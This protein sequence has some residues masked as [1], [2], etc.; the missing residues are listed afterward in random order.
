MNLSNNIS[1]LY[2]FHFRTHD[3]FFAIRDGR[4][5]SAQYSALFFHIP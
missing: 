2:V 5:L 1:F 3:F 4:M